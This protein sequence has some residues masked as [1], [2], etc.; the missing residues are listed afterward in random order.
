MRVCLLV[1]ERVTDIS[2]I[3][4]VSVLYRSSKR[5]AKRPHDL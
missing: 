2:S 1:R 4:S 3:R 5:N